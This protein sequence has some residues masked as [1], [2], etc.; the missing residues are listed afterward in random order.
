MSAPP[1]PHSYRPTVVA[2]V[3]CYPLAQF[4]P[5]FLLI[6]TISITFLTSKNHS[7]NHFCVTTQKGFPIE[8]YGQAQNI[9][10]ERPNITYYV[11]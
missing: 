9:Y 4:G 2:V 10:G 6:L 7:V 3:L 1:P 5:S 11:I 8:N